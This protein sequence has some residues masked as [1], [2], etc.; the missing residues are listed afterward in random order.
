LLVVAAAS[1]LRAAGLRD[2]VGPMV[3]G[4]DRGRG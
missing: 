1:R 2:G 3:S 4:D